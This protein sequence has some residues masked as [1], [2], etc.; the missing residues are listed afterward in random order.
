[1]V[2]FNKEL[3][4]LENLLKEC[5]NGALFCIKGKTELPMPTIE[6]KDVGVLSYPV[7][8]QQIQSIAEHSTGEPDVKGTNRIVQQIWHIPSKD[9][10]ITGR[11]FHSFYE[12]VIHSITESMGLTGEIVAAKLYKLVVYGKHSSFL[13]QRDSEKADNMFG[14][15]MLSLPCSHRGGTLAITHSGKKMYV[16]LENDTV[17]SIKWTA[18]FADCRHEFIHVTEGNRV[19]LVYN[20]FRSGVKQPN[21]KVNSTIPIIQ[22]LNHIFGVKPPMQPIPDL[23]VEVEGDDDNKITKRAKTSTSTTVTTKVEMEKQAGN[24]AQRLDKIVYALEHVYSM[25]NLTL[26]SLKGNDAILARWLLSISEEAKIKLGLAFIHNETYLAISRHSSKE[27]HCYT[28][29][30]LEDVKDLETGEIITSKS[31]IKENELMPEDCLDFNNPFKEKS[32]SATCKKDGR[33]ERFYRQCALM[34][35]STAVNG[36]FT[37]VSSVDAALIIFNKELNERG[38]IDAN[39]KLSI[40][41]FREMFSS[42]DRAKMTP[43][44]VTKMLVIL[45][46]IKDDRYMSDYLSCMLVCIG[47][48]FRSNIHL[49]PFLELVLHRPSMTPESVTEMI[50][51]SASEHV[52]LDFSLSLL[53][54]LLLEHNPPIPAHL[55]TLIPTMVIMIAGKLDSLAR[56]DQ[57]IVTINKHAVFE[58]QRQQLLDNIIQIAHKILLATQ[59]KEINQI[60]ISCSKVGNG[61]ES[62]GS[63]PSLGTE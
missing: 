2:I 59:S 36:K 28:N 19:C 63:T 12:G 41:M 17:S 14:T 62:D 23:K 47:L 42:L 6:V 44:H 8:Q 32:K 20:L 26:E 34:I 29:L 30:T 9:I 54:W 15:L 38:G 50:K 45:S 7:P 43:D 1:M 49:D 5:K 11:H 58:R 53:D 31:S 46:R 35:W 18:F 56:C 52:A 33:V 60:I 10:T 48:A 40:D 55:T 37:M 57:L 25:S 61:G 16:S 27:E 21:V 3:K 39:P 22:S 24:D 51:Q 13:P 4:P